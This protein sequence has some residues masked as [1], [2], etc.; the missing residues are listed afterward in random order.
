MDLEDPPF[1]RRREF[2]ELLYYLN[3]LESRGVLLLGVA[4]A[5]KTV[6]LRMVEGEL[7]R[8]RRAVFF[9]SFRHLRYPGELGTH[10][11]DAIAA[12]PFTDADGSG[13]TLRTS[14]GAPPLQQAAAI[15][16]VGADASLIGEVDGGAEPRGFVSDGRVLLS[17]P[18]LHPLGVLLG[19]PVQRAPQ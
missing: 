2:A 3:D 11:L 15:F 19:G 7:K 16:V 8:Q 10:V 4:G 9:V 13:R 1:I 5:G 14:A 18:A 12:S 6:L 17:T